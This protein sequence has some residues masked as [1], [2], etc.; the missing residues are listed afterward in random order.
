MF[1]NI[2]KQTIGDIM[3]EEHRAAEHHRSAVSHHEAAAR[4]HREASKHYQIGHDHAHAAHQALIA[5]GQ[6]W[7][8]VDHAKTANGYYADHDIDS[9]QKYME[10]V[11]R[12]LSKPYDSAGIPQTTLGCAEHHAVAADNHEQAAKHHRRAAQHCDEKNYM[13]AACEAHLAHG[14]AQ[15]SIFHGIEAAKHHVDHQTQNPADRRELDAQG[16]H[17]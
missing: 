17:E 3:A 11:P 4:Y 16:W 2:W 13:M 15:H 7:Q 14:H 8:A 10:Q 1:N 12:F 9:L 5:L 6:A